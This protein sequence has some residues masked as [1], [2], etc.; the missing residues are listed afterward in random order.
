MAKTIYLVKK[1]PESKKENTEWMQMS[2]EEFYRF[3]PFGGRERKI[4]HSFDG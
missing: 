4:F 2:G 3:T 1:N